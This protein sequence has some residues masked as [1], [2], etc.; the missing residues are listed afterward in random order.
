MFDAMF[1]YCRGIELLVGRVKR[2]VCRRGGCQITS[3]LPTFRSMISSTRKSK[4]S[5]GCF[6]RQIHC[7]RWIDDCRVQRTDCASIPALRIHPNTPP[8]HWQRCTADTIPRQLN[9]ARRPFVDGCRCAMS[10]SPSRGGSLMGRNQWQSA[11]VSGVWREERRDWRR[12][13]RSEFCPPKTV[14]PNFSAHKSFSTITQRRFG[15]VRL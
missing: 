15:I 7:K 2:K 1:L 11:E 14:L 8:S 10:R 9:V 6:D 4:R 5:H 12:E 3:F 13:E